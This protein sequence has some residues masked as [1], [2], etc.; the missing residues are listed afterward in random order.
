MPASLAQQG[1][2]EKPSSQFQ[3]RSVL[4]WLATLFGSLLVLLLILLCTGI[5]AGLYFFRPVVSDDP[6]N[7]PTVTAEILNVTVPE[8]FVPR[9]TLQWEFFY[10][11]VMRGAYYEL[12]GEEGVLLFLQVDSQL[13]SEED[14]REHVE[15]VLR[16]EGGGGPPLTIDPSETEEWQYNIRG[17]NVVFTV[18]K[19]Q[20][21]IDQSEHRL[22]EGVVDGNSGKV[23]VAFRI[24]EE[25]WDDNRPL[26]E[27]VLKSI[28]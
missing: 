11:A 16:E 15:Q 27:Q 2:S 5:G 22:V 14:L 7:V 23:L 26:V 21:K 20:S 24:T 12:T 9:G 28:R 4:G 13:M 17:R 25:S 3:Q 19:G 6:N 8:E 1:S 18:R 10:L